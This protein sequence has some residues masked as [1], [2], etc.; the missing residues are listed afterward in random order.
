M[1]FSRGFAF[2]ANS[3]GII[4]P[5]EIKR[6]EGAAPACFRPTDLAALDAAG[7]LNTLERP[8]TFYWGG[9]GGEEGRQFFALFTMLIKRNER[10]AIIYIIVQS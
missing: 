9:G 10:K 8:H 2:G 7:F 1:C 5:Y 4:K 6:S 3:S